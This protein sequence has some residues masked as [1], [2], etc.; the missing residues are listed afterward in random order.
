MTEKKKTSKVKLIIAIVLAVFV[1]IASLQNLRQVEFDLFMW[2]TNLPLVVLLLINT[3][4]VATMTYL[5]AMWNRR[6]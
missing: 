3:V 2:K 6:R 1:L 4:V 5:L